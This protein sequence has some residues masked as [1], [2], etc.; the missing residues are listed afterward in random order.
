MLEQEGIFYCNY[1]K[2]IK[3]RYIYM[4]SKKSNIDKY[5]ALHMAKNDKNDKC[6]THLKIVNLNMKA[7]I[8]CM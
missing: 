4:Q 3:T 5:F 1:I 7:H 8:M 6:V 2:L